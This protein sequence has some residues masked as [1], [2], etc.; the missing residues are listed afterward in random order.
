MPTHSGSILAATL[1][2]LVL[3]CLPL[4][5]EAQPAVRPHPPVAILDG[6]G[7]GGT[8]AAINARGQVAGSSAAGAAGTPER[9]FLWDG[10]AMTDLGALDGG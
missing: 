2:I 8:A 4:R 1:W 9:A 7:S 3:A 10:G 5:S 6:S